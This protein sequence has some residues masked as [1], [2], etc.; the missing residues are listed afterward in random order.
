MKRDFVDLSHFCY[1]A[2]KIGRLTTLTVMPVYAGDGWEIDLVGE[3][4]Q[5]KLARGLALDAVLDVCAFYVPHRYVYGEDWVDFIEQGMNETVDLPFGPVNTNYET[6]Y[7]GTQ[8]DA[9]QDVPKWLT[10]GYLDIWNRYFRPPTTVDERLTHQTFDV[11][12]AYWGFECAHLKRAWNTGVTKEGDPNADKVDVNAG[13]VSLY[14]I[15]RQKKY[16]KTEQERDWFNRRYADIVKDM[17]GYTEHGADERPRLLYRKSYN[18]SGYDIDGTSAGNHGAVVGSVTQPF[19]FS[20]PRWNVPERGTVWVVGLVRYPPI[21][22]R[23]QH[24]LVSRPNP[25][26]RDEAGDLDIIMAEP[27]VDYKVSDFFQSDSQAS[28]GKMPF[29]FWLR[30]HPNVI[31]RAFRHAQHF[32]FLNHVPESINQAVLVNGRDYDDMFTGAILGH[33]HIKAR[34]NCVIPRYTS[35]AADSITVGTK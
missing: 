25:T 29:G 1:S 18:A 19:R 4:Q 27:P 28:L 35:S 14:D 16:L 13:S 32:P 23:E 2:G 24:Y 33:W 9:N 17:G 21:H 34:A 7:L 8:V 12:Q 30:E 26:Y 20:V 6:G 11:E 15:A 22:E 10:Q 5:S 3:L 31:N